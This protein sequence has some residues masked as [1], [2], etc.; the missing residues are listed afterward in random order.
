VKLKEFLQSSI[1]YVGW[2]SSTGFRGV[3]YYR[4]FGFYRFQTMFITKR[5]R[6]FTRDRLSI[7]CL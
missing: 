7:Q 4:V 3:H 1:V 6:P 5:G 2:E